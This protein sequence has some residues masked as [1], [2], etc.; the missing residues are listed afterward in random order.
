MDYEVGVW[1]PVEPLTTPLTLQC[2]MCA[3]NKLGYGRETS[4]S[5]RHVCISLNSPLLP[6]TEVLSPYTP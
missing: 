4:A 6:I 1:P 3:N 2:I 5:P